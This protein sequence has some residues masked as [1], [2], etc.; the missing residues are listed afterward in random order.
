MG[1]AREEVEDY[2]DRYVNIDGESL[3]SIAEKI[4][5]W[6]RRIVEVGGIEDSGY[7]DYEHYGY[8]GAFE[9]KVKYRRLESDREYE[10]RQKREAKEREKERERKA[11]AKTRRRKEFE[12]LKREFGE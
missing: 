4:E 8:D 9:I 6:K 7:V 1:K 12:K 2:L 10:S 11:K 3:D 5:D